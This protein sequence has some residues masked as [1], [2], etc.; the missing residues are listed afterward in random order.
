MSIIAK[1]IIKDFGKTRVLHDLN[2]TI[3]DGDFFSISGRS[4]SGKSTLLYTL[5]TLDKPTS[6]DVFF[7][8]INLSHCTD[9]EIDELRAKHIGFIFQF[10]YLLSE[11]TALEN[12]LLPLQNKHDKKMF[13]KRAFELLEKLEIKEQCHKFPSEMSGGQQQRVAIARALITKPR[14]IFADEPTGNLDTQTADL[15]MNLLVESNH[16]DKTTIVLVT[17][18]PDFSKMARKEIFLV[19]GKIESTRGFKLN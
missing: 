17:H 12:I 2:L 16:L 19:D 1:N 15:V 5:S 11:L 18:E 14:Y 4:G 3:E 8:K 10:H 7:D 6:G 9:D 13:E